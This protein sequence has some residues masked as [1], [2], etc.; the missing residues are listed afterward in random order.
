[1]RQ[2][3]VVATKV[4]TPCQSCVV[5]FTVYEKRFARL[6]TLPRST[7]NAICVIRD[8]MMALA[9]SPSPSSVLKRFFRCRIQV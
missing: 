3:Q 5:R 8:T 7:G 2:F 6:T 1:M 9:W 4:R